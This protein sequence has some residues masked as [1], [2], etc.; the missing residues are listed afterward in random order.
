[1]TTPIAGTRGRSVS[2]RSADTQCRV[3]ASGNGPAA[4]SRS[5]L[6]ETREM[7]PLSEEQ[8]LALI[9]SLPGTYKLM[10]TEEY[11]RQKREETARENQ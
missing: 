8:R 1:M 9:Y 11:V 4:E 7:A 3:F 2:T 5:E 6:S 10:S